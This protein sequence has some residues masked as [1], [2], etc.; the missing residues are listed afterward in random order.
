MRFLRWA[1]PVALG[2]L[3]AWA[4]P[5]WALVIASDD[6][7]QSDYNDGWQN[8][9]NGGSGLAAW[10]SIGNQSVSGSGGGFLA[11]GNG[12]S[13]INNSSKAW[14][15]FGNGGGVGQAFRPLAS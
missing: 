10:T 12:N 8:G 15:I 3:L 11:N 4:E 5:A 6:A 2:A 7:S 9:D 1:I 14:G 13:Q